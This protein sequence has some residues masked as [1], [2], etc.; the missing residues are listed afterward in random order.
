[1]L[2]LTLS[3]GVL[4]LV[5]SVCSPWR[6]R[7]AHSRA[8]SLGVLTLALSLGVLGLALSLG[9][10]ALT[11]SLGV[12]EITLSLDVLTLAHSRCRSACSP[13]RSRRA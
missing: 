4:T 1:M 12:L 6:S 2:E 13:L 5:L 7:S 11:L 3:L 9:M 10:L 8:L